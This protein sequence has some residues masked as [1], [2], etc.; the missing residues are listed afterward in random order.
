[1][2]FLRF[3]NESK[4]LVLIFIKHVLWHL[5]PNVMQLRQ[6]ALHLL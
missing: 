2:D 4:L 1:M 3:Y 5:S 6:L